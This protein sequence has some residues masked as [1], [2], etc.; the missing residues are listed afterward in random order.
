MLDFRLEDQKQWYHKQW[1]HLL[2]EPLGSTN[3]LFSFASRSSAQR[4]PQRCINHR[5]AAWLALNFLVAQDAEQL[6]EDKAWWPGD[7]VLVRFLH[8]VFFSGSVAEVPLRGVWNL[9]EQPEIRGH[10]ADALWEGGIQQV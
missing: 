6:L 4:N 8:S 7:S 3:T 2:R 1:S 10:G 5:K 9:F